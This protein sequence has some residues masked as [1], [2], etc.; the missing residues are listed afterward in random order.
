MKILLFLYI[1]LLLLSC[2]TSKRM[3]SASEIHS[4]TAVQ[5]TVIN[6]AVKS[7]SSLSVLEGEAEKIIIRYPA[8]SAPERIVIFHSPKWKSGCFR[9]TNE[10]SVTKNVNS[11][12]T[13]FSTEKE[14]QKV[15]KSRPGVFETLT[16]L[17]VLGIIFF[18]IRRCS[19]N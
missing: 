13:V 1:P 9:K 3:K 16:L 6:R 7:D 15:R 10:L 14:S 17:F 5:T 4:E 11:K 12:D 2:N 19:S 8:D 18:F